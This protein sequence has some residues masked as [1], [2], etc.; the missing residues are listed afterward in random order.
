M[1]NITV[2]GPGCMKCKQ[3]EELVRQVVA[4]TGTEA[5]IEK[6]S[7]I[8]A[9]AAAGILSTPAVAVN[10]IVKLR[11]RVPTAEELRQAIAG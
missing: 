1:K 7:D 8:Q 4:Q 6:V 10:G 5:T 9:I 2:Y 11:G 3:T